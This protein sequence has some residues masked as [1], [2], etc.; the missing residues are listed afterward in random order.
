MKN[1]VLRGSKSIIVDYQF[2]KPEPPDAFSISK[3]WSH[4]PLQDTRFIWMILLW[5]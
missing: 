3:P 4:K 5:I 1:R 2:I